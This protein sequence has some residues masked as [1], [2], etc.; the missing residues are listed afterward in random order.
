MLLG[1]G[2]LASA[3]RGHC[4]GTDTRGVDTVARLGR[5]ASDP[6]VTTL[7]VC[8]ACAPLAGAVLAVVLVYMFVYK[9]I[10]NMYWL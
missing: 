8:H 1:S 5:G 10:V 4:V 6:R 9:D 3:P 2:L 7:S